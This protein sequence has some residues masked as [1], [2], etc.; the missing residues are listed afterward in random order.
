MIRAE[1][2][3][4]LYQAVKAKA[5]RRSEPMSAVIRRALE[6]YAGGDYFDPDSAA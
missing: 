3:D 4:D 5:Q 6:Q 2:T 1:I